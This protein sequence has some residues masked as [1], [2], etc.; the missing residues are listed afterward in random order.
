MPDLEGM[1]R[2]CP[3]CARAM[4][5]AA[6]LCSGCWLKVAP[7]GADGVEPAPLPERRPWWKWWPAR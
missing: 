4:N 5:P 6:T 1:S 2:S 7:M 3:R